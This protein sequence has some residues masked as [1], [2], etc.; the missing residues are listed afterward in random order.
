MS[1]VGG[2]HCGRGKAERTGFLVLFFSQEAENIF[3]HAQEVD[4]LGD[5]KQRCN[6]QSSTV[7]SLQEGGGS[8]ILQDFPREQMKS[9]Y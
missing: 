6:D 1:A 9:G 5:P 8:L 2:M 7:G 3:A 4:H